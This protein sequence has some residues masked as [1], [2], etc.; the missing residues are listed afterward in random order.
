MYIESIPKTYLSHNNNAVHSDELQLMQRI[1]QAMS[2]MPLQIQ[3]IGVQNATNFLNF[4]DAIVNAMTEFTPMVR[5]DD[6]R[7]IVTLEIHNFYLQISGI[8]IQF[9]LESVHSLITTTM[10]GEPRALAR[11]ADYPGNASDALSLTTTS[12]SKLWL[13]SYISRSNCACHDIIHIKISAE[14][15]SRNRSTDPQKSLKNVRK[16]FSPSAFK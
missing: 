11:A 16:E 9:N 1:I 14:N 12:K 15:K 6:P 2:T 4:W 3:S 13:T 5:R 8:S 10:P 7:V